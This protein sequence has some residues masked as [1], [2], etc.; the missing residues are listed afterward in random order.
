MKASPIHTIKE[1]VYHDNSDCTERNNIESENV[2]QG[3]GGK[4]LCDHCTRLNAVGK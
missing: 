3:T 4:R 2:R 1:N